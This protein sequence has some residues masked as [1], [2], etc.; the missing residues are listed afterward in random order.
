MKN[1][2]GLNWPL[3][4]T[5]REASWKELQMCLGTPWSHR[6]A[7]LTF[8]LPFFWLHPSGWREESYLWLSSHGI[9]GPRGFLSSSGGRKGFFLLKHLCEVFFL[10]FSLFFRFY[11]FIFREGEK[12]WREREHLLVASRDQTCNQACSLMESNRASFALRNDVQ[13]TEPQQS[14]W[15][16]L[17]SGYFKI[18]FFSWKRILVLTFSWERLF[19]GT[20]KNCK[21]K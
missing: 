9:A 11:L 8:F 15:Y 19:L 16:F 18:H 14:G 20:I 4:A 6:C 10:V 12:H 5:P 13:P 2:G 7:S 3:M 21:E 1:A 17:I